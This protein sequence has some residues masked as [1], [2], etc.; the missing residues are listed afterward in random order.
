M[1]IRLIQFSLGSGKRPAAQA[2]ADKVV[3]AIRAQ[4]GCERCDFYGDDAAGDYGIVVHWASQ[5]TADAAAAV[6][7]P[8]M[9]AALAGATGTNIRTFDVYEPT[10]K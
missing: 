6:M 8:I 9:S 7:T 3:P 2:I 1:K 10:A 5:E 4:G